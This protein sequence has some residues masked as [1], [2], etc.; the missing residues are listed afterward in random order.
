MIEAVN[1][2]GVLMKEVRDIA[3]YWFEMKADGSFGDEYDAFFQ[4]EDY[5][6]ELV[7]AV[8]CWLLKRRGGEI[9]DETMKEFVGIL[10]GKRL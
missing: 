1:E 2:S 9:D 5:A 7:Y 6:K 4:E 10:I 8:R 3:N